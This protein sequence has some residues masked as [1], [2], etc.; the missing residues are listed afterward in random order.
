MFTKTDE[1]FA[2][3]AADASRRPGMIS[4][5]QKVRTILFWCALSTTGSAL[6]AMLSSHHG[7]SAL[8][9][10]ALIQW[11]LVLKF[12]SDVRLLAVLD[13]MPGASRDGRTADQATR[14]SG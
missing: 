13:K 5:R 1:R 11:V 12:D 4:S 9:V 8:T 2:A 14:A 3:F 7:E 6:V 10:G